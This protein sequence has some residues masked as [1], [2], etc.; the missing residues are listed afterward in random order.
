VL[1]ETSVWGQAL[2]SEDFSSRFA[3]IRRAFPVEQDR[4]NSQRFWLGTDPIV[5][6]LATDLRQ[7][8]PLG[9]D[10]FCGD[11][12]SNFPFKTKIEADPC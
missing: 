3:V 7:P 12:R 4:V 1:L 5:G 2:D 10:P 8:P 11:V 9:T 6:D